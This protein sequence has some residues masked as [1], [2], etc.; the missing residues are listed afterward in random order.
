LIL[1]HLRA[2]PFLFSFHASGTLGAAY[3]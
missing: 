2:Q 1:L 3:Q